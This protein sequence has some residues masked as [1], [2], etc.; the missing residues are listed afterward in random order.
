MTGPSGYIIDT[1]VLRGYVRNALDC[2]AF[3]WAAGQRMALLMVPAIA[4]TE[5]WAHTTNERQRV[6]LRELLDYPGTR[7]EP[8]DEGDAAAIGLI[9]AS[10]HQPTSLAAGHVAWRARRWNLPVVTT[11]PRPLRGIDPSITTIDLNPT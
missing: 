2:H 11:E 10:S 4:V 6:A 5:A 9:L 8:V 3:I 7:V 1:S